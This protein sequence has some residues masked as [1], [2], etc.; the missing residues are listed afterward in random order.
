MQLKEC[1]CFHFASEISS[2]LLVISEKMK[3][4]K[5]PCFAFF[6]S[7]TEWCK[8][9]EASILVDQEHFTCSICLHLLNEPVTTSCGHSFCMVCINGFWDSEDQK[10]VYRCPHCRETFAPRPVLHKSNVLTE[11]ID[12]LQ[13][14]KPQTSFAQASDIMSF[15]AQDVECDSCISVKKKAVKSCLTCLTSYCDTHVQAH[16]ESPAFKKH[17]LTTA[18]SN[19]QEKTCVQHNKLLEFFCRSDQRVIC[20]Q[21]SLDKHRDH[22]TVPVQD[23]WLE[24]QVCDKML[25]LFN[26]TIKM[27]Y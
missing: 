5:K 3:L 25:F 10:K 17:T 2:L 27:P 26:T 16:H 8:M 1:F 11:I 13:K 21:C 12:I 22:D 19:L 24:K 23:E 14:N 7:L 15:E 20:Y 18:L 6:L 9:A 4:I